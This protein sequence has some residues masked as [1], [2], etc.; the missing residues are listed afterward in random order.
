MK[1]PL[2]P[3]PG[4]RSQSCLRFIEKPR[5]FIPNGYFEIVADIREHMLVNAAYERPQTKGSF[6]ELGPTPMVQPSAKPCDPFEHMLRAQR[7]TDPFI[8]NVAHLPKALRGAIRYIVDGGSAVSAKRETQR[9]FIAEAAR[10]LE[11][12]SADIRERVPPLLKGITAPVHFAL[13]AAL[14]DATGYP[15]TKLVHDLVYGFCN[16][17][18]VPARGVFRPQPRAATKDP[19][20]VFAPESNRAYFAEV[21]ARLEASASSVQ[22]RAN[23]EHIWEATIKEREL[24][25]TVGPFSARQMHDIFGPFEWRCMLR[26]VA[27]EPKPR[28]CDD[29][30]ANSLNDASS[31]EE[32]ITCIDAAFP[33]AVAREFAAAN[34]GRPMDLTTSTDDVEAAYRKIPSKLTQHTTVAVLDTRKDPPTVVLFYLPGSNF[35]GFPAVMNFCA[36]PTFIT[37]ILHV[38]FAIAEGA[39]FDDAIHIDP[40]ELGDSAQETANWLYAL[41]GWIFKP[42][43][44]AR[45]G[46]TNPYLGLVCDATRAASHG[47]IS[48]RAKESTRVK[49]LRMLDTHISLDSLSPATAGKLYGLVRFTLV[50]P[51]NRLGLAMLQPLQVR[52]HAKGLSA[53]HYPAPVT[54]QLRDA[55]I[56]L[57]KYLQRVPTAQVTI[58]PSQRKPVLVW[59]DASGAPEFGVGIVIYDGE[60]EQLYIARDVMP[61]RYIDILK[62]LAPKDEFINQ[63]ELLAA[64]AV[65]TTY[66]DILLERSIIHWID[67]SSSIHGVFKGYS[68][69]IDSAYIIHALHVAASSIRARIWVEYVDSK[70]NIAD[71]PTR[72]DDISRERVRRLFELGAIERTFV[73][74]EIDEVWL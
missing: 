55:L 27:W 63:A 61:R 60:T 6:R 12:L 17:G 57:R 59:T 48:I 67:S 73:F 14:V 47:Y 10:R 13:I 39:Y 36:I 37:Y 28:V 69:K 34:R 56:T 29:A 15:D 40:A 18:H 35:G 33:I 7:R 26:F 42:S 31:A 25:H 2:P 50:A 62:R 71:A 8:H 43:K 72:N 58:A 16:A 45:P 24:G 19:T 44:Q 38:L 20:K 53:L 5:V 74:P 30:K 1:R 66:P 4:D 9:A 21:K 68:A 51:F 70:S 22:G 52:Q 65:Y 54:S 49:A 32:T 64:A 11:P 46:Y 3:I 23:A 41:L